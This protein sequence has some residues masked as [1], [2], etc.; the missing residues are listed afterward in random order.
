VW[1]EPIERAD[2]DRERISTLRQVHIPQ[3]NRPFNVTSDDG[4]LP[5]NPLLKRPN[6]A[7]V[8][9]KE[10][11]IRQGFLD[12]AQFEK[13]LAA[14]PARLRPFVLLLYTTGVRSGEARKI[15]WQQVDFDEGVIR[16]S[17][18]QTKKA[19]ARVLPL[20]DEL[21]KMLKADRKESGPVFTFRS[22]RK[23]GAMPA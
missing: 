23:H 1:P 18:S 19:N 15:Q 12:A 3:Y 17:R 22:F 21:A 5:D 20:D 8:H 4:R 14:L 13:L 9:F 10:E 6:F 2:R 16:L 11:H 7:A